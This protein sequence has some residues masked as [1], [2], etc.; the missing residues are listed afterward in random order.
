M[1]SHTLVDRLSIQIDSLQEGFE[2]L[3]RASNVKELARQFFHVLRGNLVTSDIHIYY[4]PKPHDSWQHLHGKGEDGS[5]NLGDAPAA[6]VLKGFGGKMP[7]LAAAQPL[8]DKSCV[9]VLLGRKLDGS[10]YSTPDKISL[11][12]FLQ[13]FANAY[14]AHLYQRKEKELI[15]SLNHRL[16]QLNSL[17]DTGIELT[18]RKKGLS[19]QTLALE[20]AASLTNASWGI[21]T[22]KVDKQITEKLFF[23]QGI[24]SHRVKDKRH[25]IH[26]SFTFQ[27]STY[28]FEL[29]EKESRSG[30]IPFDETDQLL[31]DAVTRQ[32]HAVFESQFLHGEELEKQKI[33]QDIAVAAAIQKRILPT[34]LPAIAGYDLF[35]TNIPTKSVGG[36][37]YDCI[38]LS[39][40]AYA[41]VI[42]DVAGKGVPAALL[43][44]SFHAYLSAYLESDFSLLELAQKLNTAIYQA[45]TEERYVTGIIGL[46]NPATGGLQTINAGHNPIYLLRNDNTVQELANGGIAFGMID[47]D[48]PYQSD[49]VVV[50]PGERVLLYTDGVTEAMNAEKKQYDTNGTLMNF[51]LKNRPAKAETFIHDLISDVT[52]FTGSAPQSDDITAMYVLRS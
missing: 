7:K 21:F 24:T 30:T 41:L 31:L 11:Q 1:A 42:A 33:E 10:A 8:V 32:V 23:P 45:S 17:I 34:T 26:A 29:F 38:P 27:H 13:L 22:K 39:N 43:V 12:I 25:R 15:F 35:G 48:F 14:Q 49:Q 5:E 44:S 18:G 4:K 6:F 50:A 28:T 20:R 51:M 47:M 36:D 19:P 16:L 2:L 37:Y 40:G 9:G 46:L 52:N 3:S